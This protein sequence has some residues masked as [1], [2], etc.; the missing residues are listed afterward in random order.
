[1]NKYKLRV[2]FDVCW[3]ILLFAATLAYTWAHH[4]VAVFFGALFV[5]NL[6]GDLARY[7]NI[8]TTYNLV[9]NDHREK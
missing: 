8:E 6:I 7:M 2:L 5:I 4:W 1:M 3:S 9:I